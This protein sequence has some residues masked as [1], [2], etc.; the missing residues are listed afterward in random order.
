MKQASKQAVAEGAG[1]TLLALLRRALFSDRDL[2]K[3]RSSDLYKA[4]SL[5]TRAAT[6]ARKNGGATMTLM[7]FVAAS[8][9]VLYEYLLLALARGNAAPSP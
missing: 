1:S 9:G 2:Y 3:A 7:S 8:A 5:V 6:V 4:R